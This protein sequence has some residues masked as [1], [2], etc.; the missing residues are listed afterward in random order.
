MSTSF[1]ND[2]VKKITD[3]SKLPVTGVWKKQYEKSEETSEKQE[4]VHNTYNCFNSQFAGLP[5][6]TVS[7]AFC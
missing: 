6:N 7:D 4:L 1:I 2:K 5:C 3:D